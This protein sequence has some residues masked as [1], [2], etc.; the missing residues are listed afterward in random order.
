MRKNFQWLETMLRLTGRESFSQNKRNNSEQS[1]LSYWI[2]FRK[3][4]YNQHFT[5]FSQIG[6]GRVGDSGERWPGWLLNHI[7]RS[8]SDALGWTSAQNCNPKCRHL[9]TWDSTFNCLSPESPSVPLTNIKNLP[10]I[11]DSN[12]SSK[13]GP[14]SVLLILKVLICLPWGRRKDDNNNNMTPCSFW[15]TVKAV[16]E[17]VIHVS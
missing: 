4:H 17:A 7:L 10:Y 2:F 15:S 9:T 13:L 16:N 8:N 11:T 12:Q 6:N 3:T 1:I 14:G 5:T